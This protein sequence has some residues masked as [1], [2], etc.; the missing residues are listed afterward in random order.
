VKG[1]AEP[2]PGIG[3]LS[4]F[5]EQGIPRRFGDLHGLAPGGGGLEAQGP[6]LQNQEASFRVHGP[7]DV[8]GNPV[9]SLQFHGVIRQGLDLL[10]GEAGGLLAVVGNGNLHQPALGVANQLHGLMGNVGFQQGMMAVFGHGIAVRGDHSVHGIGPQSPDRTDQNVFL[11][12]VEGVM[13][14]H[15]PAAH[16]IDHLETGHAHGDVLVPDSHVESVGDGPGGEEARHDVVVSLDQ[17]GPGDIEHRQVLTGIGQL[18][19]FPDGAASQGYVPA[20]A[21]RRAALDPLHHPVVGFQDGFPQFLGDRG[22]DDEP[23]D[24]FAGLVDRLGVAGVRQHLD[25]IDFVHQVV[26]PEEE[27]VGAGGDGKSFGDG[28]MS[29][30]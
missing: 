24:F 9:M 30:V 18:A 16:G 19:V 15:D 28:Q 5:Q 23:L 6:G 29:P 12:P 1:R 21:A 13:G 4:A 8:L 14:V 20:K 26:G 11:E 27:L 2:D 3:R 22:R 7:L 17:P 10:G 25:L